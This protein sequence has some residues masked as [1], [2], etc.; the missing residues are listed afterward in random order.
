MMIKGGREVKHPWLYP[1]GK[2]F[3]SQM[4]EQW[5]CP[6]SADQ[7]CSYWPRPV[8]LSPHL[9]S[10]S[11]PT[12]HESATLLSKHWAFFVSYHV[13][14]K[15]SFTSLVGPQKDIKPTQ[16]IDFLIKSF[17]L[18]SLLFFFSSKEG[19]LFWNKFDLKCQQRSAP[20]SCSLTLLGPT[21]LSVSKDRGAHCAPHP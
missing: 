7:L 9:L 4:P 1:A 14:L 3:A 19:R 16:R 2:S 11:P 5:L 20:V 8:L 15:F 12:G 18:L 10:L 17:H 21:Y 6:N 13:E